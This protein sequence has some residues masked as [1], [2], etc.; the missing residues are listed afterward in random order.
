MKSGSRSN[1]S[2]AYY[3]AP[4][5]TTLYSF[6]PSKVGGGEG[7]QPLSGPTSAY[8]ALV[9]TT[10]APAAAYD[11]S[12]ATTSS[13][14]TEA[15]L[16]SLP[17][18]ESF[19][20]TPLSTTQLA[21]VEPN[22]V[23]LL[24]STGE[25]VIK[26]PICGFVAESGVTCS[27]PS[28]SV[29][30]SGLTVGPAGELYGT[31]SGG[32]TGAG[33]VYRLHYITANSTWRFEPVLPFTGGATG[34]T[35]TG[36]VSFGTTNGVVSSN[37]AYGTTAFG[38]DTA[39]T[40]S[41]SGTGCGVLYSVK[42]PPYGTLGTETV[43]HKFEN[44]TDGAGPGAV[45]AT[46]LGRQVYGAT[47]AGGNGQGLVFGETIT[48]AGNTYS[49][50]YTFANTSDGHT[51]NTALA[52]DSEGDL[53]GTAQGGSSNAGTAFALVPSALLKKGIPVSWS[54]ELLHTF[55][56]TGTDGAT[57]VGGLVVDANGVL[58]GATTLGGAHNSGSVFKLV[59]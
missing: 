56:G 53:Y 21:G 19:P 23:F 35:P 43:L 31:A 57:P 28:G 11:L 39:C 24:I 5:Y 32:P 7:L 34:S 4:E 12:Q 49:K 54:F 2:R 47:S 26:A 13:P 30:T 16:A 1:H 42:V 9:G 27:F 17:A 15:V 8:G 22:D 25:G 50:I 59:P 6:N 29:P 3:Y 37:I 40:Y 10:S 20:L 18:G 33:F 38:G 51:P 41:T 36:G 55:T 46:S 52:L 44:G 45:V 48:A 58:Y 14:W